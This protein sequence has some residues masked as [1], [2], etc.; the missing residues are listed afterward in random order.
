ME[1]EKATRIGASMQDHGSNSYY[2][3]TSLP[4]ASNLRTCHPAAN[5]PV[6][7]DAQ[8]LVLPDHIIRPISK[9]GF[10]NDEKFVRVYVEFDRELD[11]ALVK[12]TLQPQSFTLDYIV[13]PTETLRLYLVE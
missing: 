4:H 2:Y 7:T 3:S 1:E 13:S 6:P 8:D 5:E 12:F 10:L 11:P 9:Y